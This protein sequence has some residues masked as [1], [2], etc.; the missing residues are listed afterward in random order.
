MAAT[1]FRQARLETIAGAGH[2]IPMEKPAEVM[3]AIQSFL[4]TVI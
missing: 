1:R 4:K 2:L 3:A